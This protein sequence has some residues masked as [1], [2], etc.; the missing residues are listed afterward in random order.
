MVRTGSINKKLLLTHKGCFLD[1]YDRCLNKAQGHS[2]T[3]CSTEEDEIEKKNVL[4]RS[5]T[6]TP[7]SE[8]FNP[9][10]VLSTPVKRYTHNANINYI[11]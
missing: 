2:V 6:N 1:D 11:Y 10:L 8:L 5:R 7:D 9:V 4:A 3:I